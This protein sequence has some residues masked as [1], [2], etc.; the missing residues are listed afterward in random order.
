MGLLA[1]VATGIIDEDN[2][3]LQSTADV[4]DEFRRNQEQQARLHHQL[5]ELEKRRGRAVDYADE[6]SFI[7]AYTARIY[8]SA[9]EKAFEA[10][11]IFDRATSVASDAWK[12]AH[13]IQGKYFD[14]SKSFA[15]GEE[16]LMLLRDRIRAPKD[17]MEEL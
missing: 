14:L 17:P 9:M 7:V 11:V 5:S 13:R 4:M 15:L 6:L 8:N 16:E 3:N 1:S 10:R 12:E 2:P